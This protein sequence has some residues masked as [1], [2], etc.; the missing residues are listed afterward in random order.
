MRT[1]PPVVTGPTETVALLGGQSV[2]H[3]RRLLLRVARDPQTVVATLVFPAGLL[4]VLNAVTGRQVSAFAGA[5][6]LYGTVP[7]VALVAAMS[8]SVAGAVALGRERDAGLPARFWVLPVHR[9]ADPLAR[10]LAEAARILVATAVM[11]IVGVLLG[12]R[13]QQGVLAGVVFLA[14]PLV[15]GLGFATM[16]FAAAMVT[17]RTAFVEAVSLLSSLL[18]FFSTGF[19]PLAACPAWARPLVAHQPLTQAIDA[20]RG[21]SLGGPVRGPLLATLAWSVGAFAVFAGPA[22]RG[23]R[24]AARSGA[25]GGA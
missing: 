23:Y 7:M 21:L 8:G 15:F 1:E 2:L 12:F 25:G 18:M 19:V 16:V 4:M 13:F 9:G 6:A 10:L 24:R 20:M 22:L 11:V 14:V 17:T 5:S 3:T